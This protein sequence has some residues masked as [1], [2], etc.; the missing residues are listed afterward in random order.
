MG[1][2]KSTVGKVLAKKL[3]WRFVDT[4]AVLEKRTKLKV[5]AFFKRH[6]EP[7]FRRLESGVLRSIRPGRGA[8]VATG[9]GIVVSAANRTWMKNKGI[10]VWLKASPKKILGWLKPREISGRPLL[11]RDSKA[12]FK[13]AVLRRPYYQQAAITVMAAAN[14]ENVAKR[15]LNSLKAHR[16]EVSGN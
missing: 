9:G 16:I 6:G 1:S 15:V 7:R 5:P 13:L 4:D 10:V 12:L 3:K 2:G 8:V 11:L 14:P